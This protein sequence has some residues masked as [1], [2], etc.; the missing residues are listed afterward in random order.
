MPELFNPK[1]EEKILEFW[2]RE[3]IFEKSL[4][5]RRAQGKKFVFYEGPPS[6]NFSPGL[7]HVL[8]RVYKDIICRYKAMAGFYA[9]RKAGW[10]THGLPI[11]LQVEKELG[12][13]N[14]KDIEKYGV[15]KF[16]E[17]AREIVW[18]YKEEWDRLTER[19]GF[20]L[21]LKNPYVTYEPHYIESL[22][23]LI[24]QIARKGLL[25]QDF[26]VVPYCPRCGTALSSHEVA[27]GYKKVS[28]NSI[29]LRFKVKTKNKDWA[30]T[31]I[32][33]WTTTPWTLPGNVALAV[34]PN[35][36]YVCIPD[37]GEKGHW[38]VLG[39][40]NFDTLIE[41]GLLPKEY[42]NLS[43]PNIDYFKGRE[44]VGIEYEPL[45]DIP[46]LRSKTSY[47]VYP[48]DFVTMEDGTGVVHTAVMYGIDDFNLGKKIGLPKVHT[49][50]LDGKFIKGISLGL[51]GLYVK[52]D[53]AES[54][55]LNYLRDNNFLFKTVKYEHDYPFCWRCNS[56]LLYYAKFS[57]FI[58]ME[59]LK[60]KLVDNNK[61]INWVPSHIKNGRFGGWLNEI[62]DWAFSRERYWGTPLPV[63]QCLKCKN[64]HV[65]GSLEEFNKFSPKKLNKYIF[66]RHGEAENNRVGILSSW[67]EKKKY[68]L[69]L[70]GIKEIEKLIPWLK[71]KKIDLI[72]SSDL[73]RTKE[74]AQ[75]IA[76]TLDKKIVYDKRLREH[77]F[78]IY[79]G[80]KVDDWTKLFSRRI[81]RYFIRSANGENLSDVKKRVMEFLK[82]LDA[83]YE[84]KNI[85]IISHG[86]PIMAA[87][88]AYEGYKDEKT[89]ESRE[90]LR[91][92]EKTGV[93]FEMAG[94]H[95]PYN[96]KGEL[97]L[98]RP[99]VDDLIIKCQKCS[100]KMKRVKD[101]IDVWFD[102]GAM[103]FAQY[104]WPFNKKLEYPADFISEGVDQTRGWFYTLHAVG[105]LM[106]RGP[107]FKN[108]ICLGHILDEKGEKMSKSKGNVVDP[109]EVI[110]KY[111]IDALRWYFFTINPP[112]ESKRFAIRDVEERLRRFVLTLSNVLIFY[113][114]YATK[115]E[116][117]SLWEI[118]HWEK[119]LS[120]L[121]KWILSRLNQTIKV[122]RN[123]LDKYE[124]TQA[125]RPIDE[126][127][128][129]LSR[130][131]LRRSRKRFSG[132]EAEIASLVLKEILEKTS[133]L[134]A[135]F[136]PFL[137]E[138][139]YMELGN[140]NSIHLADYPNAN[141]KFI[142]IG[143][144]FQMTLVKNIS[145]QALALRAKAGIKVRQPLASL[146]I[147]SQKSKVK[148][149]DELLN[150]IK[151]EVNVKEIIF[152]DEIK[153]DT[154]ITEEL[155][156]EGILREL[157]RQI[158]ELRR[159]GGLTP[160]DSILV[161]VKI[162]NEGLKETIKRF[163]E[164][165]ADSV[166]AK[167]VEF[168]GV[169]K[170]GLLVD[171]HFKIENN[172][173]IWIGI[174]KIR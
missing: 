164:T 29:Y 104:H 21:D 66:L 37:P 174:N 57:W 26:K 145:A 128:D 116:I 171:R 115:Q 12:L 124:V 30:N 75:I 167:K 131:W 150:L 137:A 17:K 120:L 20:W 54:K 173:D 16:N 64:E 149:N 97:D 117:V 103:P 46:K 106:E 10:D 160:K 58:R 27:L 5:L 81:D 48:A 135:P 3:Q 172:K 91:I 154:E 68:F 143:L 74:T 132:K 166:N 83:K 72:F 11:E 87:V 156:V 69:T 60:K 51:D 31:S 40:N 23:Y 22:W 36:E 55:I 79:N 123:N 90:A 94:H 38:L 158:Q 141:S 8:S 2:K 62:K 92:E 13:K 139:I 102:S 15:A 89:F 108:V 157:A 138:Y 33:S 43:Q 133:R 35:G 82:F 161:F 78:G 153:L 76:G 53:E 121:D 95:W 77:D 101:V 125:A 114:T 9:P 39:R 112:G 4:T 7:H 168:V 127:V 98:H 110:N 100:G 80:R 134:L 14:K 151:E 56:P 42:R 65:V 6:S 63:W 84:G 122:V 52:S 165:L 19:I 50:D 130:W 107:A 41:K 162:D 152:G 96:E 85:L 155:K 25:Y 109:W 86:N 32:L 169:V 67:P 146:K 148:I 144:E 34:N 59:K 44:I 99:Y 142:D 140:N 61:K 73:I 105:T 1:T 47:K 28:E 24:A 113:K 170:D 147:K 136:T 18:K 129:D 70:K 163:Q 71:K 126:F 93:I 45:F 159:D 119:N 49:V 88:G 111:G 118:S